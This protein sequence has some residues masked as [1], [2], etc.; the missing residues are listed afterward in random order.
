M[1]RKSSL[2]LSL[3]ADFRCKLEITRRVI[4]SEAENWLVSDVQVWL[5]CR[6][7]VTGRDVLTDRAPATSSSDI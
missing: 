7:D 5:S 2:I 6:T 1:R 3:A 4:L